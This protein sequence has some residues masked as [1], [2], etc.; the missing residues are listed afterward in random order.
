MIQIISGTDRP[1]SRTSTLSQ[2]IHN[3][4][5]ELGS[6]AELIDLINLPLNAFP[7]GKYM[8]KPTGI[9][10]E[11]IDKITE[12]DGLVIVVP[13]YNGSYPGILKMFID[14]WK[15][16]ETFENRPVCFVGLGTK[17]GGLRPVEHLQQVF[18]YRN[19]FICPNR[20]FVTNVHSNLKDGVLLDANLVQLLKIQAQEFVKFVAG[21]KSQ[22]L[23]AASKLQAPLS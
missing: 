17:W 1:N 2:I 18:G 9:L 12:A 20:V 23:D 16:P 11:Y 22:R 3:N 15:Y 4:F 8:E 10:K 6:S 7:T 19:G 21:L 14:Y 5:I 13:E